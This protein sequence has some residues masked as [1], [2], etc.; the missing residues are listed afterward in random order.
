MAGAFV[1]HLGL[2]YIDGHYWTIQAPLQFDIGEL[3]SNRC[4]I[5]TA[6]YVTDFNSVPRGLWNIFPPT[7]YGKS[8]IIHDYLCDG[9]VITGFIGGFTYTTVPQYAETD[10]IYKEALEVE[11]C[12]F[13]KRNMMWMGVR[14]NHLTKPIQK[15]FTSKDTNASKE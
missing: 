2:D 10:A 5:V 9:G 11:G 1:G 6:G 12:P 3:G 14:A 13:W 15:L 7:R 8:S 4:V